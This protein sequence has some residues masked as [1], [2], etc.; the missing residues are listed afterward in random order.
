MNRPIDDDEG[1]ITAYMNGRWR[2]IQGLSLFLK[3]H[4][5]YMNID[6]IKQQC[7]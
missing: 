5:G 1:N 7:P 2:S 6:I 3:G 4:E